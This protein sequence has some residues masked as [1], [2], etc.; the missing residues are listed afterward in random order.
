[1]KKLALDDERAVRKET[2]PIGVKRAMS[3]FADR[4]IKLEQLRSDK[5]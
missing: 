5:C 2:T 3:K 4:L 1:M